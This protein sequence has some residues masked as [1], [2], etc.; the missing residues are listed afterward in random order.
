[1]RPDTRIPFM[2]MP[3]GVEALLRLAAAPSERLTRT[4][5]NLGAFNPSAEEIRALVLRAFPQAQIAYAPDAKR[6]RIVDS[7]PEDV[8]DSAARRD[9][10]FAPRYDL[11]RAF[12]DYLVPT[13]RRRYE[14]R[15]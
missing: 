5:Y 4:V 8:D 7:W 13:I 6:Q 3:D 11:E 2:A 14:A 15:A 9:W 12:A 1:V 10:G